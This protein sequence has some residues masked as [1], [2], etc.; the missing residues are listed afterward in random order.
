MRVHLPKRWGSVNMPAKV[1][2]VYASWRKY[3][4]NNTELRLPL[5]VANEALKEASLQGIWVSKFEWVDCFA[6]ERNKCTDG[7]VFIDSQSKNP[8]CYRVLL[9]SPVYTC[10][11]YISSKKSFRANL[12]C[13]IILINVI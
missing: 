2:H 1:E 5:A 11:N 6:L 9:K 7:V 3:M 4:N 13:D 8:I 10:V 12:I